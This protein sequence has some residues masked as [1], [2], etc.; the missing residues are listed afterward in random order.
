LLDGEH[1]IGVNWGWSVRQCMVNLHPAHS[2]PD[3]RF[4]PIVGNLSLDENDPHFEEAIECSSNR[5]A[6]TAAFAFEAPRSPRLST[7]AYIPRRFLD[8]VAGLRSIRDFIEGDVSYRRIFGGKDE[9]GE[10]QPGLMSRVDTLVT[11]LTSLNVDTLPTYRPNLIT[12]EDIPVLE[13]AGVDGDLA[14][15]LIVSEN[16]GDA[17]VTEKSVMSPER[18]LVAKINNLIVGASP[19]DF[20][21]VAEKTRKGESNGLGVVVLAAGPWKAQT[22]ITA[23]R[24]GAVNELITDLETAM[25]IGRLAGIENV[26]DPKNR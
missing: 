15:H 11:G 22:L 1:V 8:D 9:S 6:Q 13:R 5:L 26:L 7:P 24:L 16:A 3:L 12:T 25:A 21:R 20:I 14:L 19:A 17:A 10:V 18:E 23:I 2:N 4:I